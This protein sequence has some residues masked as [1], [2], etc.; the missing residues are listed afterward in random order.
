MKEAC[1]VINRQWFEVLG[2]P[3]MQVPK[4]AP[5]EASRRISINEGM[6]KVS[7]HEDDFVGGRFE[8]E[9]WEMTLEEWLR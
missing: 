8:V 5:N 9:V 2:M 4:A 3:L 6:R 1:L 7:S